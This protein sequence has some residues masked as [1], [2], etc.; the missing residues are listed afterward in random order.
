MMKYIKPQATIVKTIL[1]IRLKSYRL[2]FVFEI[3]LNKCGFDGLLPVVHTKAPQ[4]P[5]FKQTEKK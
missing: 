2:F 4:I 5:L 3:L 1:T